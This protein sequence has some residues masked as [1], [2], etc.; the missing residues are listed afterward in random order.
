[1]IYVYAHKTESD[2]IEYLDFSCLLKTKLVLL[3]SLL[4]SSIFFY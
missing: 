3:N 1:M 4:I 2:I